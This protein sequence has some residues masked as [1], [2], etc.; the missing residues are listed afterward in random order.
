MNLNALRGHLD[1]M[2]LAV[3]EEEPRHGYAIMEALQRRSAGALD[4][5]TGTLY[6]AL[7]RLERAGYLR[8]DWSTVGGRSRRTYRLTAAG[9]RTL[10]AERSE[11]LDFAA[12]MDQVL[13][14]A[15]GTV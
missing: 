2:I 12:V 4:L 8:S 5:P 15:A 3:L 7:R 9:E 10:A 6:P 14:P 1:A 13:R 11:W